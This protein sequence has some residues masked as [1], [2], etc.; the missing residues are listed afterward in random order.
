MWCHSALLWASLR[1]KMNQSEREFFEERAAIFEFEANIERQISEWMA[2]DATVEYFKMYT[3]QETVVRNV[4]AIQ[5]SKD[6]D[7][8]NVTLVPGDKNGFG[9]IQ[10]RQG[11]KFVRP[12]SYVVA[13]GRGMFSIQS[14]E[15]FAERFTPVDNSL[16]PLAALMMDK[17]EENADDKI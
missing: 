11:K 7:H 14:P 12:G 9:E 3:Y 17:L 10:T 5:W 13:R 1:N 16:L 15:R 6:G 8:P 4:T 2:Y